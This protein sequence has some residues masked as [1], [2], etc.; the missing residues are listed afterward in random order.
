MILNL[1]EDKMKKN[2]M[3][4]SALLLGSALLTMASAT[5]MA[6]D[7]Q[8]LTKVTFCLDW[9]P[10]TNHTGVYVAKALGYYEEAGMDVEIVQPPSDG[11]VLMC[12]S[13]QAQFAIGYEDTMA[14]ALDLDEPIGVTAVAA[15]LQH[16]SSGIISRAGEGMDSPA[17]LEGKNYSTWESPIEL[18][19]M[20]NVMEEAG[21]DYDSLVLIPNNITD[22][23]AALAAHQTDAIWVTMDGAALMLTL[24]M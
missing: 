7:A 4:M 5:A 13:G 9:T 2:I 21:A 15:V 20:E 12:A 8:E 10:N 16:N 14:A 17:G 1:Q 6:E 22:E 3:K 23:P 24:K 11:A 18:A 19:M